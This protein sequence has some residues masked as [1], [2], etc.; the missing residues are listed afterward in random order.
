[1]LIKTFIKRYLRGNQGPVVISDTTSYPKISW[2]LEAARLVVWIIALK[3]NR[4]IGSSAAEVSAKFQ[5]DRI[6]NTNITAS[7]LDGILQ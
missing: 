5:S 4:H 2:S 3:F 1:M 6:L 7:G